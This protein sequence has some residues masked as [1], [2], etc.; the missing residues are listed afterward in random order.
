M[1]PYKSNLLTAVPKTLEVRLEVMKAIRSLSTEHEDEQARQGQ[2]EPARNCRASDQIEETVREACRELALQVRGY[3][4]KFD[5]NEPRVPAGNPD[6]GQWTTEGG[7][8]SSDAIPENSH[9]ATQ[10]K[11]P[12][13]SSRGT[14]E[15][16]HSIDRQPPQLVARRISPAREAE[17]E[18]Q[19]DRDIFHCKMVGLRSCYQQAALRYANCLAGLD[20]PPLIYF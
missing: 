19:H 12:P 8:A 7:G 3:L 14:V 18:E 20:I 16:T 10:A 4:R 13:G 15:S 6:G 5:P 17:C 11:A 9:S 2:I 1:I